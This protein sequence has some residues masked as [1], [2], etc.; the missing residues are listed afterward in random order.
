LFADDT[1]DM[2]AL[3]YKAQAVDQEGLLRMLNP[4]GRDNLIASLRARQAKAAKAA[5]L[6]AQMGG[7]PTPK[8]GK[9]HGA[10]HPA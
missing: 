6:K 7:P 9:G 5:A 4:A 1:R 8:N 10:P 3:L 2:A